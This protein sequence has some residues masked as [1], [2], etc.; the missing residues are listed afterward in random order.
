MV[1]VDVALAL[2]AIVE[3]PWADG[4]VGHGDWPLRG[5]AGRRVENVSVRRRTVA[6]CVP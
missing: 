4:V 3:Q 1:T 6:A 2:S 5:A